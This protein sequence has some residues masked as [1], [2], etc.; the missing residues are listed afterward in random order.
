MLM[1][2]IGANWLGVCCIIENLF[3]ISCQQTQS[4]VSEELHFI[5]GSD[6]SLERELGKVCLISQ[7]LSNF[8]KTR[9]LGIQERAV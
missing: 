2:N 3:R 1:R 8:L 7:K 6:L 4:M 5:P 9:R